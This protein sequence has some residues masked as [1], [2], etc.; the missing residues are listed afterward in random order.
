ML[1]KAL[2]ATLVAVPIMLQLTGCSFSVDGED[3]TSTTKTEQP[4]MLESGLWQ[5][6]LQAGLT[7]AKQQKKLVFVDIGAPWCG[8]CKMLEENIYPDPQVKQFLSANYVGVMLQAESLEGESLLRQY[9]AA[10][11]P[12]L[13][14][15]DAQGQ[16]IGKISGAPGDANSFMQLVSSLT[17]GQ[18]S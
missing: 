2:C 8:A 10:G 16:V 14:V 5:H 17:Q 12:A 11:L 18:S 4:A 3:G 9:N 7:L 15:M 13:F 1:K 6:D